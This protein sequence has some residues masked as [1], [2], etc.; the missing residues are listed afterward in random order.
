MTPIDGVK[1]RCQSEIDAKDIELEGLAKEIEEGKEELSTLK[2]KL[3]NKFG[4]SIRL[5]YD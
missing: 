5:D 1:E 2:S 3:Y 4:D